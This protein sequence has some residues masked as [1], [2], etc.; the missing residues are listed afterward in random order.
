MKKAGPRQ[1]LCDGLVMVPVGY[2]C[3][4]S[5]TLIAPGNAGT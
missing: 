5:L 3:A 4:R 1:C 2:L